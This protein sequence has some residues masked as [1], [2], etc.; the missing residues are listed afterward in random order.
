MSCENDRCTRTNLQNLE[1]IETVFSPGR[2]LD[3]LEFEQPV[4]PIDGMESR[5]ERVIVRD[6]DGLSIFSEIDDWT[7]Q[8]LLG[9]LT[10]EPRS[11]DA[12]LEAASLFGTLPN[13][14]TR[15][16]V[17]ITTA[18]LENAYRLSHQVASWL[19]I[20]L[21]ARMVVQWLPVFHAGLYQ[22]EADVTEK[23]EVVY[24][25][26]PPDWRLDS[27]SSCP[28]W[29]EII[30]RR[31]REIRESRRTDITALVWGME[32]TRDW[33]ELVW[34][35]RK[36]VGEEVWA[37]LQIEK[38]EWL[39]NQLI[40]LFFRTE[41]ADLDGRSPQMALSESRL[42]VDQACQYRRELWVHHGRVPQA[43][44]SDSKCWSPSRL[45]SVQGRLLIELFEY[46]L[47]RIQCSPWTTPRSSV[48]EWLTCVEAWKR[49]FLKANPEGCIWSR[50][51]LIEL[52]QALMPIP[53][54]HVP[55]KSE[56][57]RPAELN[58]LTLKPENGESDDSI[59]VSGAGKFGK[60]PRFEEIM[61]MDGL[62]DVV[63]KLT[64]MEIFG[65]GFKSERGANS[66]GIAHQQNAQSK[67]N[68]S[69]EKL[70]AIEGNNAEPETE[71]FATVWKHSYLNWDAEWPVEACYSFLVMRISFLVSEILMELH[72]AEDH[73]RGEELI[74]RFAKMQK[75]GDQEN[76]ETFV[77]ASEVFCELL[78]ELTTS[79]PELVPRLADLQSRLWEQI[80]KLAARQ[81]G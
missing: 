17:E 73:W 9:G 80:R 47:Q 27:V 29:F 5:V 49:H 69:D 74:E 50:N 14:Q 16:T 64:Q 13:T 39:R 23:P 19:W 38:S 52:E 35:F 41:R 63:G 28:N 70:E 53:L 55:W 34:E 2:I 45:G 68:P 57:K 44:R 78:E 4:T 67:Q 31:E 61:G 56:R 30:G 43:K 37:S 26:L 72:R 8:K 15:L 33:V 25:L 79:H 60:V 46:L 66:I 22:S 7:V 24:T 76:A 65:M 58:A 10:D 20:D 51:E 75:A 21:T 48:Q 6:S 3:R 54:E 62:G 77:A 40:G 1:R 59:D 12:L 18:S 42:F 81:G 11:C 36:R 32:L 71:E